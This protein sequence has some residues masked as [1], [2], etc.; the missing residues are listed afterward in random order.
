MI[1]STSIV[2][3]VVTSSRFV[4]P[5]FDIILAIMEPWKETHFF[6][7]MELLISWDVYSHLCWETIAHKYLHSKPRAWS[8]Y[9][10]SISD[11]RDSITFCTNCKNKKKAHNAKTTKDASLLEFVGRTGDNKKNGSCVSSDGT[12]KKKLKRCAVRTM[13]SVYTVIHYFYRQAYKSLFHKGKLFKSSFSLSMHTCRLFC[14]RNSILQ[15]QAR[16]SNRT[17]AV[18]LRREPSHWQICHRVFTENIS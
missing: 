4:S 1:K 3:S 18:F 12:R 17:A 15:L 13:D 6:I 11:S 16:G 9:E 8:F 5:S 7:R 14:A 10:H 2:R